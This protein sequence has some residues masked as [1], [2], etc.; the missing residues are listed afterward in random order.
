[1]Q[2]LLQRLPKREIRGDNGEPYLNRYAILVLGD[3]KNPWFSLY[4]HHFLASDPD[5]GLHDHPWNWGASLV[6]TGG[7]IELLD[8]GR[9]RI[10][11]PGA[12]TVFGPGHRHRVVLG[13]KRPAW[14]LF[15][16]GKRVQGWSFHRF[17]FKENET[18]ELHIR[19]IMSRSADDNGHAG[20][21]KKR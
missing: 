19:H 16:H 9:A 7:Y 17:F 21:W 15:A 6:L 11:S 10:R 8:Y 18:T 14:T 20:W 4:L 3:E 13:H 5:R 1:M 12:F 2:R